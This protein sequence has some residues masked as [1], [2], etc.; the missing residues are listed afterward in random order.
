MESVIGVFKYISDHWTEILAAA[1]GLIAATIAVSLLIPGE[2]PEKFFR[3]V[4]EFLEKFS[5]K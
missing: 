4:G 3:G 2:Q 5:K 1:N